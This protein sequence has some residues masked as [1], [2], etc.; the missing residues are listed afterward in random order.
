MDKISDVSGIILAGGLSTRIGRDKGGLTL[1]GSP[2]GQRVVET[3]GSIFEE[4]IYVTNDPMNAPAGPR[5]KLAKDEV[6]HLGPLGGILAGLRVSDASRSFIVGYD[7]PFATKAVI[8]FLVRYAP[9]A[10]AVVVRRD[11]KLE[12]LHA[13][14]SRTCISAISEQLSSGNNRI[15]AF[16]DRIKVT[17]VDEAELRTVDP[18][19]R[20][21]FNVNTLEDLE[22]AEKLL[23][24]AAESAKD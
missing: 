19:L 5:I 21:F 18:E 12:P 22:T 7:M 23:R 6:P 8:D 3:I 1:G 24:P 11:D 13:V 17:F 2:L 16:Y 10:D 4:V 9:G 14:Y 20:S 15:I